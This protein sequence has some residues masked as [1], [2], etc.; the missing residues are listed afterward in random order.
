MTKLICARCGKGFEPDTD[1]VKVPA[2]YKR[3][4][5]RD[6]V[7]VFYFHEECFLRESENWEEPA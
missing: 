3:I 2:E 1:H 5:D 7:E 6:K 4:R